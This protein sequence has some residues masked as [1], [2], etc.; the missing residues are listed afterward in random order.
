MAAREF[1]S[2]GVVPIFKDGDIYRTVIVHNQMGHWGL[3]KG[4]PEEGEE[5]LETAVRELTEETGIQNITIDTTRTFEQRFMVER[6]GTK[7][8]KTVMYYV[9]IADD[10]SQNG[11]LIEVRGAKWVTLE[12]AEEL[13]TFEEPK[14]ILRRVK[15]G[16]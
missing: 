8:S 7:V 5:P 13:L 11:E 4:T 1:I 9:G 12:E 3:P 2:Y 6:D 15:A 10:M 16:L 14:E